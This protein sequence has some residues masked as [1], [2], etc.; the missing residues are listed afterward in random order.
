MLLTICKGDCGRGKSRDLY[1]PL[2]K[3]LEKVY[4]ADEFISPLRVD[5]IPDNYT[6]AV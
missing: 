1:S 6:E 4:I 3:N 5:N 2:S